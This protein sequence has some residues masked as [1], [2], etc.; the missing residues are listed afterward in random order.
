[1]KNITFLLLLL[2]S[3]SFAQAPN[4]QWGR[5][6]ISKNGSESKPIATD[7]QGNIF[8][9]T[10]FD[11]P[12]ITVGDFTLN[13]T[14]TGTSDLC[15]AK[16]NSNGDV[17]WAKKY[18]GVSNDWV[19]ALNLDALGNIYLAGRFQ[20]GI[21]LGN[22][23]TMQGTYKYFFAKFD[24][25]GEAIWAK[26]NTGTNEGFYLNDI[27]TDSQ[28]NV[29]V[30]GHLNSSTLTFGPILINF[31]QFNFQTNNTT[32][33]VAKF[34]SQGICQWGQGAQTGVNHNIGNKPNSLAIDSAGN[35][36][37]AG[38]MFNSSLS[39]GNVVMTKAS[40]AYN[41]HMY[42]IKYNA[43]GVAQWGHHAGSDSVNKVSGAYAVNCTN[44]AV[45]VSG[46][47]VGNAVFGTTTITTAGSMQIFSAKYS[48]AGV[49]LWAK[50]PTISNNN[51][52]SGVTDSDI[53][54][55][56][57]LYLAGNL[58]GTVFNFGNNNEIN[59]PFG[60]L[61]V[62]KLNGMSGEAQWVQQGGP[63]DI[64]NRVYVSVAN[65]GEIY[66]SSLITATSITLGSVTLNS[67]P[68][69][70][71]I[72]TARLFSPPLSV[73]SPKDDIAAI[74]P[75]PVNDC[76]SL[77]SALTIDTVSIY[78]NT[79]QLIM[80]Q[81]INALTGTVDISHFSSGSYFLTLHSGGKLQNV[82][83]LKR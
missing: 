12:Q 54:E 7:A 25:N 72:F 45:Y 41:S 31:P 56:G 20:D 65:P 68:G 52:Y 2:S 1:M 46:R 34:D 75:N 61:F 35:V 51:S 37:V 83:L 16:Y 49:A 60:S 66:V 24:N 5:N 78:N 42:L 36:Y 22:G 3:I 27:S 74:W 30:I 11:Q 44:D 71:D 55:D 48:S 17:I 62:V 39:F 32:S 80:N 53:D 29:Y 33:F 59:S 76:F 47:I 77:K 50:T 67:S 13:N 38:E 19:V 26:T 64:N 28:G 10:S 70:Y 9:V 18:G 63:L 81:E 79:G 21:N 43:D 15:L 23:I 4:W 40:N 82:K 6:L 14:S 8:V 57:N 58:N 69:G 73:N